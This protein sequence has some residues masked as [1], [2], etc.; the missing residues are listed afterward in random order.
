MYLKPIFILVS[1]YFLKKM[2][3]K[4]EINIRIF[5]L[6]FPKVLL[7]SKHRSTRLWND[8]IRRLAK[9]RKKEKKK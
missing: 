2:R 3:Q 9:K 6:L 8:V 7:I 5:W 4:G 1:L